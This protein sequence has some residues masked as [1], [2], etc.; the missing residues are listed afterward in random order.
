MPWHVYLKISHFWNCL[1][2]WWEKSCYQ[3]ATEKCICWKIKVCKY[4]VRHNMAIMKLKNC[5]ALCQWNSFLNPAKWNFKIVCRSH[6]LVGWLVDGCVTKLIE[7]TTS[8]AINRLQWSLVLIISIKSR[9]SEHIL[10]V[11]KQYS[12]WIYRGSVVGWSAG[13]FV[14]GTKFI[15]WTTC[16]DFYIL[17]WNLMH[18]YDQLQVQYFWCGSVHILQ[19]YV[20]LDIHLQRLLYGSL[21]SKLC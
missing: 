16:T 2:G 21:W 12:E 1:D 17:Q 3:S 10:Y 4:L 6:N 19:S 20:P 7:Q 9:D 14:S 13:W 8:A 11:R 5:S 18:T 15:E